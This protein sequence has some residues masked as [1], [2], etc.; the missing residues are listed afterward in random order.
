[1]LPIDVALI[2]ESDG[3]LAAVAPASWPRARPDAPN[4]QMTA[5]AAWYMLFIVAPHM[6]KRCN[7]IN[8]ATDAESGSSAYFDASHVRD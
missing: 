5:S 1:M 8:D 4:T 6:K 3:G 2:A 7:N